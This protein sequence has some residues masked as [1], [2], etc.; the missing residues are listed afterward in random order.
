MTYYAKAR[1]R[2]PRAEWIQ[3]E[4][5]W[6]SVARC[7]VLTVML[8]SEMGKATE[9]KAFIDRLGCGG[10]CTGDHSIVDLDGE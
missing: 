10:A 6:A 9:A 4:G 2:W 7:R 5:R 8:H 3:G 1:K